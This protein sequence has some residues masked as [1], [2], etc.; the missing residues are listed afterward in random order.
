MNFDLLKQYR[1]LLMEVAYL[2]DRIVRIAA[3]PKTIYGELVSIL[4]ERKAKSLSEI[5]EIEDW[6]VAIPDRATQEYLIMQQLEGLSIEE[7]AE[8]KGIKRA[9][10]KK[11]IDQSI[12]KYGEIL[13]HNTQ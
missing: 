8:Q 13:L 1:F 9:A 10:V 3:G 2:E 6:I 11:A 4:E 5:K 7:I 12:A